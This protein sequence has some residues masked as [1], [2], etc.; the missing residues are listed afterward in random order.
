MV[1]G[2][3]GGGQLGRMLALAGIPLGLSFRFF[4]P[5]T[6]CP[7]AVLGPHTCAAWDDHTALNQFASQVDVVTFEFEN[8]PTATVEFLSARVP[9]RPGVAA[10]RHGQDRIAEK[11]F[12]VK[13]GLSVH[14]Y[15]AA[16]SLAEFERAFAEIGGPCVAKTRRMGYDGKGQAVIRTAS[17][18]APAW[19]ALAGQP[20]L[21]EAFVAFES[22]ASIIGVRG[23]NGEIRTYPM[24]R[25]VHRGGIL[26][27]S[28]APADNVG[29]ELAKAAHEHVC[30]VLNALDYV[31]VLAIEFFLSNGKLL[32]NEM[33]PRVH[34][35]GH[36]TIEGSNVSQFEN[37][38]R[39]VAGLPLGDT[40]MRAGP[41]V[42]V[43]IIGQRPD[44]A[45]LLAVPGL[46]LHDYA[47]SA[48]AGR[49]IGHATLMPV[50]REWE[51]I[52]AVASIL[53]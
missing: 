11:D 10:L 37:H 46:H 30:A 52:P 25:N 12:F 1:I 43:N 5:A 14:P 19:Q 49:K 42:M 3:L 16:A 40:S 38:V 7:A 18:I 34:N 4:D 29:E 47:K 41:C 28:T 20:L 32:A 50:P 35:S 36:W 26:R 9:V 15:R 53:S 17:E 21:V 48:K 13:H 33:A 22:E 39:A 23:L 8:V 24:A 45:A 2:V 27:V 6:E 51:K 31:G 44:A